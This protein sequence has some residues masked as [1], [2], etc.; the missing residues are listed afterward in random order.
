MCVYKNLDIP[1]SFILMSKQDKFHFHFH[2]LGRVTVQDDS[3]WA[4][5]LPS[6]LVAGHVP[7]LAQRQPSSRQLGLVFCR[8]DRHT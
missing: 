5:V 3:S 6:W 2:F 1:S 7:T 4:F 8:Y